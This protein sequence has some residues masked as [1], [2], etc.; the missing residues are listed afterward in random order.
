MRGN[1]NNMGNVIGD[2]T[3]MAERIVFA[4][5]FTV[6][7]IGYAE[8]VLFSGTH[9]PGL[10]PAAV[11]GKNQAFSGTLQLE[12]GGTTPGNGPNNHDQVIDLGSIELVDGVDLEVMPWN[13]FQPSVGDEF[14]VL[15]TT[16]GISGTFDEVMVDPSFTQQGID[17]ELNYDGNSLTLMAVEA[18]AAGDFNSDGNVNGFDFLSWQRGGSPDPLSSSDLDDWQANYGEQ[19]SL[20][21]AATG[22][23]TSETPPQLVQPAFDDP[24]PS[25]MFDAAQAWQFTTNA[26]ESSMTTRQSVAPIDEVF[27]NL[28]ADDFTWRGSTITQV[29]ESTE[30]VSAVDEAAESTTDDQWLTDEVLEKVFS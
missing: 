19:V 20:V 3:T 27:E 25:E 14:E 1:F 17:F 23:T 5:G 18:R 6:K 2:G 13:G 24:A 9:S 7:G 8:N 28:T 29:S 26:Q 12:L 30:D 21:A 10:S 16:S 11:T 15:V 22:P 4:P